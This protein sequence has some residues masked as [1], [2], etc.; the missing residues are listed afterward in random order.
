[1]RRA[2]LAADPTPPTTLAAMRSK[3]TPD[4][5]SLIGGYACRWMTYRAQRRLQKS[6]LCVIQSHGSSLKN[7][8]DAAN[9][10]LQALGESRI[11]LVAGSLISR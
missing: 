9:K 3:R 4:R 6:G 1:M 10:P 2:L 7:F 5:F 8:L 11:S